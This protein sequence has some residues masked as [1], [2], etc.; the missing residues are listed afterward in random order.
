MNLSPRMADSEKTQSRSFTDKFVSQQESDVA[1]RERL[2]KATLS[3]ESRITVT[4]SAALSCRTHGRWNGLAILQAA[5]AP[6]LFPHGVS[7]LS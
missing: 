2:Y 3:C 6:R 1:G 5:S 7:T 4:S